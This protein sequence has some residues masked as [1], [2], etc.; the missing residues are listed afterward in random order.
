MDHILIRGQ[1]EGRIHFQNHLD[2]V[3][4]QQGCHLWF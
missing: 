4:Q 3:W 1:Q 2:A